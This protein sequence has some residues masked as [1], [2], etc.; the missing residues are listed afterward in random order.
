MSTAAWIFLAAALAYGLL[1]FV[2]HRDKRAADRQAGVDKKARIARN[3]AQ[4]VQ[5]SLDGRR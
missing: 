5:R 1:R 3:N 4:D 2:R